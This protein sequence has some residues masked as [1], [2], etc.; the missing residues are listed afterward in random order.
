MKTIRQ[1]ATIRGATPH[2]IY[3]TIM[4]SKK[5]TKLSGSRTKVS[6]RVGGEFTVGRDLEGK[7]LKLIQ[8]KKIVQSWRANDWPKGHYSRATFV[9]A[10]A[11]G[12]TRIT[13]FQSGVPDSHYR[14]I[15]S[16]WR[17]YYWEPLQEQF[18][19]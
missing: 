4:D 9:L 1:T 16:G 8:D 18:A 19:K 12:G 5:H 2:D 6:R 11:R 14:S 7:N 10:P 13:F 15:S 17:E 3:E